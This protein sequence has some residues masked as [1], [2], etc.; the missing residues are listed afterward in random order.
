MPLKVGDTEMPAVLADLVYVPIS[1]HGVD[2][3]ADRLG[4]P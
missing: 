3:A 4:R 2:A 1:A